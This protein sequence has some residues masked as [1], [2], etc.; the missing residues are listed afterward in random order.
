MGLVGRSP[1]GWITSEGLKVTR[2]N[3]DAACEAL[4]RKPA[5]PPQQ[6]R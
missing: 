1:P 4:W 6:S 3:L 2:E 5:P